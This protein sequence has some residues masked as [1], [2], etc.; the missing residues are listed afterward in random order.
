MKAKI[1]GYIIGGLSFLARKILVYDL[2]LLVL[3]GI[4]F[5]VWGPFSFTALSERLVL[6]GLAIAMVAG[7]LVFS[8]TS[9]GRNFGVPGQF[10]GSV[11]AQTIIDFNIEVRQAIETRMGIFPRMFVIGAILF[12]LGVL[13]Q[14][15]FAST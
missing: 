12:G 6:T 15:I 9:G 8:Q 14:V 1:I 10:I 4:S 2:A 3:V 5:W 7:L 11:H 13:V